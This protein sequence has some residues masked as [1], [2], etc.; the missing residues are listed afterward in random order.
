M[1]KYLG[2]PSVGISPKPN[3]VNVFKESVKAFIN[4]K[5]I[6]KKKQNKNP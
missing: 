2:N 5:R 4:L 6:S 3:V 1:D